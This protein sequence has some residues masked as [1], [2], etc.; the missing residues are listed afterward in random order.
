[1]SPVVSANHEPTTDTQKLGRSS[2]IPLKEIIT[3]QGKK[4]KEEKKETYRNKRN[5]RDKWQ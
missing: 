5:A 3:A 4:P 2:S 1:M